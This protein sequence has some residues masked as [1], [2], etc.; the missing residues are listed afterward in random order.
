[1]LEPLRPVPLS[2]R[3]P[4]PVAVSARDIDVAESTE[5]LDCSPAFLGQ[6]VR[7]GDLRPRRIGRRRLFNEAAVRTLARQL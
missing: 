6:L 7:A 1:M 2:T 3:R 5:I 4:A